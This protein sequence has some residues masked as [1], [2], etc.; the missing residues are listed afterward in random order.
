MRCYLYLTAFSGLFNVYKPVAL[1]E[2]IFL[3]KCLP[4]AYGKT[5]TVCYLIILAAWELAA[6]PLFLPVQGCTV[7]FGRILPLIYAGV[8]DMACMAPHLSDVVRLFERSGHPRQLKLP[9]LGKRL[10]RSHPSMSGFMHVGFRYA[11]TADQWS[12][13]YF[14]L[15]RIPRA[16][17]RTVMRAGTSTHRRTRSPYWSRTSCFLSIAPDKY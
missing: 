8:A 17:L 14:Q 15:W 1:T 12:V 2:T 10:S 4:P 13:A 9:V 5:S 6:G 7:P 11:H 16:A 3:S